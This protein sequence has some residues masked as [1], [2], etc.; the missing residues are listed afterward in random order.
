MSG[1]NVIDVVEPDNETGILSFIECLM[2]DG[3]TRI[4]IREVDKFKL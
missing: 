4:E 1:E 2:T 3:V